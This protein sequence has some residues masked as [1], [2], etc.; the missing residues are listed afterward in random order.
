MS[1]AGTVRRTG[2]RRRVNANASRQGSDRV[3]GLGLDLAATDNDVGTIAGDAID[4]HVDERGSGLEDVG[5]GGHLGNVVYDRAVLIDSICV[6]QLKSTLTHV[7]G[8]SGPTWAYNHD[9]GVV[10]GGVGRARVGRGRDGNIEV[11]ATI[12]EGIGNTS[13]D[14]TVF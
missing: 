13:R 10:G 4:G 6:V 8:V 5:I 9:L 14:R 7:H 12:R 1:A 11:L 3:H 2:S